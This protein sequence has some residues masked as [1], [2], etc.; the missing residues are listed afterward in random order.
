MTD[1]TA[2]DHDL[3][4]RLSA[5]IEN[6]VRPSAQRI[7]EAGE[8]PREALAALAKNGLLGLMSPSESG[9][10]G[11]PLSAGVEVIERVASACGSTAMT[12]MMHYAASAV[13]DTHGSHE[14]QA[15]VATGRG[16]CTLA[17]S[18]TG[19]RSHFWAPMSTATSD[20]DRI[21]L[22]AR[23][24]W[25]TSA[26][27]ADIYVWSS[28]PLGNA[29][30]GGMTLW[31]VPDGIA[32]LR[33]DGSF[34]GLG[35]CGNA[36]RPMRAEAV[37][38]PRTAILGEDGDGLNI[39][40]GVI[41]PRFLLL[42]A[43]F[44]LGLMEALLDQAAAHL[45]HSRLEHLDTNLASQVLPRS[46]FADLRIQVDSTR[47]FINDT[48]SALEGDRDDA[49]LRVLQVKLVAAEAASAVSDGVMKLCGGT[50]FRK[51]LG[52]ERQFRDSL[53][54]R[55]MAPTSEALRD[56]VGRLSLGLPLFDEEPA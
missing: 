14:Q 49:I 26:G 52:I 55:V 25:V 22:D 41:L 44:S 1:G 10:G 6:I 36:S 50:A 11:A 54:A 23:K 43:A 39:A 13:I 47:A 24:S 42:N 9:G 30:T 38:V 28:R 7:D 15:Q 56:F 40:L 35:L 27:E 8:Y 19:S 37:L 17:F 53:A 21:R 16:L 2:L 3:D 48:L 4:A 5:I 51:E 32:G 33:V 12:L 20:G 34:N 18:E 31:S 29:A 46:A 45:T